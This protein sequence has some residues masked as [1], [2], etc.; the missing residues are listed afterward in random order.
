MPSALS[1]AGLQHGVMLA[2]GHFP[3]MPLLMPGALT[4]HQHASA[5]RRPGGGDLIAFSILYFSPYREMERYHASF[6]MTCFVFF[7]SL[8]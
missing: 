6:V 5:G 8:Q 7:P 2:G 4:S 1:C 3:L